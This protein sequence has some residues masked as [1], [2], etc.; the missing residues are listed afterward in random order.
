MTVETLSPKGLQTRRSLCDAARRL[1]AER[2]YHGTNLADITSAAD[3]SPGIFYRYF[4]D[5]EDILAAIADEVLVTTLEPTRDSLP[6]PRGASDDEYFQTMTTAYWVVF[7]PNIGVMIAV[8][9]LADANPRLAQLRDEFRR[10]SIDLIS[11]SI[12]CAQEQGHCRTLDPEQAGAALGLMFEGF[13]AVAWRPTSLGV[14]L[15]DGAAIATL[16]T[17]WQRTLYGE[18]DRTVARRTR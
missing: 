4:T 14:E 18:P 12:R 17:I 8:G 7:K 2:G 10:F 9:Q 13:T 1:F 15:E 11:A 6:L 3:K 16:A 5:K